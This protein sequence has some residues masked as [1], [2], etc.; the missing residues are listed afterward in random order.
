MLYV[1]FIAES[2]E[3][4][5]NLFEIG[6]LT[7]HIY[8]ESTYG[9]KMLATVEEKKGNLENALLLYK[10]GYG[11]IPAWVTNKEEFYSDIERVEELLKKR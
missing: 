3:D 4:W 11:K 10:T 9:Y 7:V 2:N 1:S 6:K 5:D 8:P